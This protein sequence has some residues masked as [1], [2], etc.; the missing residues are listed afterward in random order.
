MPSRHFIVVGAG[1]GGLATALRL[2]HRGH[3]VTVLEQTDQVG[4]RNREVRVNDCTFDAGPTL[5]MMLEPF[6]RLFRDVGERFEDHVPISLCDPNY[7]VFFPDGARLNCTSNMAEMRRNIQRMSGDADA[8]KYPE[9]IGQLGQLYREA[10][11]AFVR[12]NYRSVLDLATPKALGLA[13][14]HKMLGNLARQV[15]KTFTDPRLHHLFCLQTMYLGLSPYDA[16]YVYGVLVYMEYGEGIWYPDGGTVQLPRAVAKLA[17]ARG[18]E[19][20]LN[21]KVTAIRERE[22][23]LGTGEVLRAD[24]VISNMDL[25]STEKQLLGRPHQNRRYSCSALTVYLD[26]EGEI[27]E[28]LHHNISLGAD[29][30]QNLDEIFHQRKIP[31]DPAYYAAISSKTDRTKAPAGHENLY[32][33]IPCPNLD[34]PFTDA[35]AETLIDRAFTRLERESSFRRGNIRGRKVWSPHE[36]GGMLG[37]DKGATFGLSHDFMQSVCFRPSNRDQK[38]KHLYYVGAS[39]TPGNGLPMV[40]IGAELV[41][42]RLQQDGLL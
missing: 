30:H 27:P 9:F 25:P 10:I 1:F 5:L 20:R 2:A 8:S 17:Q 15:E 24:A 41:E 32:L 33:L 31:T 23:T 14:R 4:G 28:L 16:P 36:W 19:I 38:L 26:Y 6:E 18:A 21:T 11:P 29:F 3:R 39:T 34:H 22:V 37:L 12:R 35:D 7:R 13:L 42:Q 40:L